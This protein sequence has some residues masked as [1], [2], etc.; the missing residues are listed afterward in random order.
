VTGIRILI[1]GAGPVPAEGET[2]TWIAEHD[3]ELLVEHLVRACAPLDGRLIFAVRG[4]D[5]VR[6]HLDNVIGLAAKDAQIVTITGE[7]RGAA[8]TA[9]LGIRHIAPDE[10]LLILNSNELVKIDYR[11]AVESFRR[12]GLDAGVVVFP[13]LHPRYSYVR[14]DSD[15][16]IVEAAEKRPISRHATAGFYWYRRGASFVEAAQDMI[17]K[18]A[19]VDGRFFISLTLN[20]LVLKQLR[21]GVHQIEAKHY[22]PL[23]SRQQI[24]AFEAGANVETAL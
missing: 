23:K 9:L 14:F 17:R 16:L 5:L 18:D 2:P 7:T 13:S 6:F 3:G 1:L 8:C 21:M 11:E 12:R 4:E 10:E 24:A 15:G 20:E 19:S 22:Q